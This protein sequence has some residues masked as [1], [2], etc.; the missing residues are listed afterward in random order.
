MAANNEIGTLAPLADIGRICAEHDVLFH[1][2][3]VQMAGHLPLDVQEAGV[4]LASLSA[5]KMYGPK[6]VGALYRRKASPRVALHPTF[7]GG[8]H[9]RGIR[10]G[11]LNVPGIVGFGEAARIAKREMDGLATQ[12]RVW[13]DQMLQILQDDMPGALR[14][15][16]PTERLPHNLNVYLP[17]IESRALIVDLEGVAL[18]TGSACTSASVEPSHVLQALGFGSD[19]AHQSVRLS[20]GRANTGQQVVAAM[21]Q[22][23]GAALNVKE[24]ALY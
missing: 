19:R 23:C 15:G 11:T 24:L 3:A 8:G 20:L 22:V 17:G 10:S 6:G 9:E 1:S 16:H 4:H 2:D 14:N 18:A 13:S 5:H 21:R 12:Y 7:F